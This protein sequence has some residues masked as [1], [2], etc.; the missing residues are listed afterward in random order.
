VGSIP[1]ARTTPDE[2]SEIGMSDND[3]FLNDDE[4]EPLDRFDEL[5]QILLDR[6]AEFAED[7]EVDDDLLP[8]LM[9][10]L[11]VTLRMGAYT[12]SV[13]KP[14]AGGLKLELDRFRRDVEE[15]V[16]IMKKDAERFIKEAKEAMLE[17]EAADDDED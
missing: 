7:E 6:V 12:G 17:E 16:R 8:A 11:A 4:M 3:D 9:L 13:A 2:N 14:S 1:T 15:L 10:R 5:S